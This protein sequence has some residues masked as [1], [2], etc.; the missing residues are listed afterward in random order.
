[1]AEQDAVSL[2]NGPPRRAFCW[3]NC[4]PLRDGPV[5]EPG[6]NEGAPDGRRGEPAYL[7]FAS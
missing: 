2:T 4:V 1:M 7:L 5:P 3:R 6:R